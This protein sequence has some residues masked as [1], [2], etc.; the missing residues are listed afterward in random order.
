MQQLIIQLS[1]EAA[2]Q[3]G[4]V[5]PNQVMMAQNANNGAIGVSEEGSAED[6]AAKKTTNTDRLDRAREKARSAS[7]VK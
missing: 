3:M 6:R 1:P 7:E 5:D 4:L 2:V